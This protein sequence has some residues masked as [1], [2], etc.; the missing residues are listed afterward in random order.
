MLAWVLAVG[1]L[2]TGSQQTESAF[3][4]MTAN[5]GSTLTAASSF[6]TGP[7][8]VVVTGFEAGVPPY[9]NWTSYSS[10]GMESVD[11]GVTRSGNYS[12]K[13]TKN[14]SGTGY[15]YQAVNAGT[16]VARVAVRF[17]SLPTASVHDMVRIQAVAGYDLYLGYDQ[18][19]AKLQMT[20]GSSGQSALSAS[21]VSA[22]VWYRVDMRFDLSVTPRTI[23]WRVDGTAQTTVSAANATSTANRFYLGS[24]TVADVFTTYYDDLLVSQTAADYPLPDG[25]VQALVPDSV[26]AVNDPVGSTVKDDLG[27][28]VTVATPG[29]A[30]RID[31]I[32]LNATNDFVKHIGTNA[33]S[34]A[35][36]GFAN[37]TRSACV[38]GVTATVSEHGSNATGGTGATYAYEGGAQTTVAASAVISGT[39]TKNK[40]A[41]VSPAS[42]TWTA[43]KL[44]GVTARV[45]YSSDATATNYPAWDALLLEYDTSPNPATTYES[46]VLADQPV[47][48]W[49][50]GETSGTTL[51]AAT[52][53]NGTYGSGAT[54]GSSSLVGDTDTA[55]SLDGTANAYAQVAYSAT[56]NPSPQW[57]MEAWARPTI[58]KFAA[59]VSTVDSVSTW[60]GARI[61]ED[62]SSKKWNAYV[63]GYTLTGAAYTLNSWSHL[64][65][66]YDGTTLRLYVNGTLANS[67]TLAVTQNSAQ[68]LGIGAEWTTGWQYNFQGGIDEVAIYNT[69]LSPTRIQAHYN[70]GRL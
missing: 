19:S 27:A 4:T 52:G 20:L 65:L 63:S 49:R 2:A 26:T 48:Y 60:N 8:P 28:N 10:S 41:L 57:T 67:A 15:A 54:L 24:S 31:E 61:A 68:P 29:I 23:E 51:T 70:T 1:L 7:T 42:G 5:P 55:A 6:C 11:S 34:Y 30:T 18:P 33:A 62:N 25:R 14:G 3:S 13:L 36:F 17:A 44:N 40:A 50:L 45:G 64:V 39:G 59:V 9:T 43:A 35:E 47:G 12:F 38:N 37:S 22:G 32:P 69:A 46:T 56:I 16:V 58:A 53:P 66:T 21:A